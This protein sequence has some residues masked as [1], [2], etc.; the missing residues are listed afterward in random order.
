MALLTLFSPQN[1]QDKQH[2]ISDKYFLN[3]FFGAPHLAT[4]ISIFP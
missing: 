1:E 4:F 3:I 2:N